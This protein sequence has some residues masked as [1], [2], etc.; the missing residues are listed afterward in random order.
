MFIY[1]TLSG[2]RRF[3]WKDNKVDAA[4]RASLRATAVLVSAFTM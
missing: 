4:P 1:L 3:T 2:P